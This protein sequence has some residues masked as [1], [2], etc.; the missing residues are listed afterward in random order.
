MGDDR[1]RVGGALGRVHE[2]VFFTEGLPEGAEVLKSL[3]VTS[4][5][6]NTNIDSLKSRLASQVKLA[7]GNVLAD[8]TYFQRATIF[9]FSSVRWEATGK[10]AKVPS[11]S[12]GS[13]VEVSSTDTKQCKYCAETVLAAAIKCKHCGEAI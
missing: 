2:D 4:D 7:G 10:A 6:Q 8:F 9:S 3:Q 13:A 1:Y 5:V 11:I 12:S